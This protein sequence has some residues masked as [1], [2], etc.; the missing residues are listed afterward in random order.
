[1]EP[2][3]WT[4]YSPYQ[5]TDWRGDSA[6]QRQ[7][8]ER[9]DLD[10]ALERLVALRDKSLESN[11]PTDKKP[12]VAKEFCESFIVVRRELKNI[13]AIVLE[14]E[15]ERVNYA[16]AIEHVLD[17]LRNCLHLETRDAKLFTTIQDLLNGDLEKYVEDIGKLK[18][19][20][21]EL[22]IDMLDRAC[23]EFKNFRT[24]NNLSN[25]LPISSVDFEK[26]IRG[27]QN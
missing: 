26:P 12:V 13:H 11:A 8:L 3:G 18:K 22:L 25:R 1:M 21:E 4:E 20:R 23:D 9:L 16:D 7:P 10:T 27:S 17:T 14:R 24:S 6:M 2:T 19:E 5:T 15:K